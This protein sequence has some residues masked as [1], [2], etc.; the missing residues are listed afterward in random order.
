MIRLLFYGLLFFFVWRIL[1]SFSTLFTS[2]PRTSPPPRKEK[3]TP[4]DL[5]N[6]QDAEFEDITN[7]KET[8]EAKTPSS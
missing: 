6:I 2:P 3:K 4:Q 7:K 1:R 8:G 5:S